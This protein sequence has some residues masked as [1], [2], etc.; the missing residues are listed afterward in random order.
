[1]ELRDEDRPLRGLTIADKYIKEVA[2]G[3]GR[4]RSER[5]ARSESMADLPQGT[6]SRLE[7]V[8]LLIS[9]RRLEPKSAR[10]R[11]IS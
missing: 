3:E 5:Q 8:T 9:E 7:K 4:Q 10:I 1:L 11:Q 6:T 2:K